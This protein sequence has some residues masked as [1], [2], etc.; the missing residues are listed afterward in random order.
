MGAGKARYTKQI[1]LHLRP[2]DYQKIVAEKS[3]ST[4][5]TVSEYIRKKLTGRRIHVYYR[6]KSFDDFMPEAILLRREL[7]SIREQFPD[8]E[9]SKTRLISLIEEIKET[10]NRIADTCMQQ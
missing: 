8:D 7:Q 2:E 3:N 1:Q 10:V 4:C 9:I 6:N 5:R